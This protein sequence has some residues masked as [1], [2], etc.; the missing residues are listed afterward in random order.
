M[1]ILLF[2]NANPLA[3]F[4]IFVLDLLVIYGLVVYGGR[5]GADA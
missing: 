3:A 5:Q 1:A 4:S 2:I